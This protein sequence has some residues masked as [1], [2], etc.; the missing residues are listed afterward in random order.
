[1]TTE[2]VLVTVYVRRNGQWRMCGEGRLKVSTE[3]TFTRELAVISL[4]AWV[5]E[6]WRPLPEAEPYDPRE[7]V[8]GARFSSHGVVYADGTGDEKEMVV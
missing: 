2:E 5:N 4:T 6:Y 3:E 8:V 7:V 1:M